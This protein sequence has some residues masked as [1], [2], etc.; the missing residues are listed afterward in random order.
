MSCIRR[1]V[2]VFPGCFGILIL[3]T[4]VESVEG[5]PQTTLADQFQCYATHPV[6]DVQLLRTSGDLGLEY[7]TQLWN[8]EDGT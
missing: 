6:H 4:L 7:F 5:V 1:N 8:G 3:D 2:R